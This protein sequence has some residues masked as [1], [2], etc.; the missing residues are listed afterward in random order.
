MALCNQQTESLE[1]FIRA[2]M[3]SCKTDEERL[4]LQRVLDKISD[5]QYSW[6]AGYV[7]RIVD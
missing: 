6:K 1:G 5:L 4:R 7:R 2:E 3:R